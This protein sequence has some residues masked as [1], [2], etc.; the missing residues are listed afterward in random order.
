MK[1]LYNLCI[2][3][4]HANS[5]LGLKKRRFGAGKWDGFGGKVETEET[6]EEA[7]KRELEEESGVVAQQIEKV[8]ILNFTTNSGELVH[9]VHVLK[10][11]P[12]VVK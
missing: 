5:L 10:L 8:G 6:I 2:V 11:V 9:E 4:Q 7:A 3:Y 1:K 12:M